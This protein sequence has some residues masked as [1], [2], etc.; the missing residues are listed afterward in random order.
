[1]E[2]DN[3]NAPLSLNLSDEDK[4]TLVN[5]GNN[6]DSMYSPSGVETEYDVNKI[7]YKKYSLPILSITSFLP[8]RLRCSIRCLSLISE[9]ERR[10][11]TAAIHQQWS[12]FPICRNWFGRLYGSQK[13][14]CRK[15]HRFILLTLN[16]H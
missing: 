3:K 13:I 9:V 5:A 7:L 1:M 10:L 8:T 4:Q 11:S 6:Q 2:N 15:N 14:P 16:M 12:R